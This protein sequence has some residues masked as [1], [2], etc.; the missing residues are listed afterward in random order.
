MMIAGWDRRLFYIGNASAYPRL[1]LSQ[2]DPDAWSWSTDYA[3]I[4]CQVHSPCRRF[5]LFATPIIRLPRRRRP[6]SGRFL[7]MHLGPARRSCGK[8][9]PPP[10][11]LPGNGRWVL[12]NQVDADE[13][14]VDGFAPH[15]H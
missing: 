3:G 1:T 5:A 2:F 13:L 7:A 15:V 10:M 12:D 9:S 4:G 11:P 8:P 6:T 14:L